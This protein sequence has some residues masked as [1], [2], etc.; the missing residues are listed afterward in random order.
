MIVPG[1]ATRIFLAPGPTYL[2]RSFD[3]LHG[4][5]R[6]QLQEDPRS[7]RLFLFC[8]QL[9]THLKVL[10][11]DGSGST[12]LPPERSAVARRA[13]PCKPLGAGH[14]V[15][16]VGALLVPVNAAQRLKLLARD[17]LQADETP[18]GVQ[19]PDAPKGQNHRASQWQYSVP[20]R[21]VVFDFQMSHSRAGP[22]AFF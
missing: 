1:P 10:C 5:V 16:T 20:G 13:G 6:A 7:G 17:Y 8:N 19:S 11:V 9:C 21:P 2:R 14:G 12:P 22:A 3:G 15:M 18:V 4:L